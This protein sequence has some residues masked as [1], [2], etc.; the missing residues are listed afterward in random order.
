MQ[1][2][3]FAH[4]LHALLTYSALSFAVVLFTL[5]RYQNGEMMWI[6]PP[7][8]TKTNSKPW[9]SQVHVDAHAMTQPLSHK[10]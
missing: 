2:R 7:L 9:A 1:Q 5:H 4:V 3:R 8:D 10:G 6:L